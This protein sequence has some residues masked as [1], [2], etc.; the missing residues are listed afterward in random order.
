[1]QFWADYNRAQ[2]GSVEARSGLVGLLNILSSLFSGSGHNYQKQPDV[3][4]RIIIPQG[5]K[6][7]FIEPP[8]PPAHTISTKSFPLVINDR[9]P[10]EL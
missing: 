3:G 1:M 10:I 4:K 2:N 5:I 8:L 6:N 7:N 9:P